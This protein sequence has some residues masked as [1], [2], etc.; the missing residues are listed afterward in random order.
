MAGT[1]ERYFVRRK[2]GDPVGPFSE[3][4]IVT[5]LNRGELD[6]G[7]EISRDRINWS[8]VTSLK[9]AGAQAGMPAPDAGKPAQDAGTAGWG[10]RDLGEFGDL[11]LGTLDGAVEQPPSPKPEPPPAG[12]SAAASSMDIMDIDG[13]QLAPLDLDHSGYQ[14]TPKE[15]PKD[16]AQMAPKASGPPPPTLALP[17]LASLEPGGA[18]LEPS[19]E[20][21]IGSAHVESARRS[22]EGS[23]EGGGGMERSTTTTMAVPAHLA[24]FD[25]SLGSVPITD[26]GMSPLAQPGAAGPRKAEAGGDG[27]QAGSGPGLPP[28]RP[29]RTMTAAKPRPAPKPKV[30]RKKLLVAGGAVLLLGAGVAAFFVFE[31]GDV[32]AG[33]PDVAKV[34]GDDTAELARDRFPAYERGAKRLLDVALTRPKSVRLRAAAAELLASSVVLRR[35]ERTRLGKADSIVT[36]AMAHLKKGAQPPPELARARAWIAL[37]KGKVRE[38]AKVMQEAGAEASAGPQGKLLAAWIELGQG[39]YPAAEKLFAQGT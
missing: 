9:P 23:L 37:G 11:E 21:R 6:A 4:V 35:G 22:L 2:T 10:E 39:K 15:A 38:A 8:S 17:K 7:A 19:T 13:L 14:T 24:D 32:I 12:Q 25:E 5:M 36:D 27:E 16:L 3:L 33:D 34:L 26:L 28:G 31:L 1:G 18:P 30:S 20:S 29:G